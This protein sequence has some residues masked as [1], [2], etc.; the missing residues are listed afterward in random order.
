[1]DYN[2]AELL[3]I[4]DSYK[5]DTRAFLS[6]L[7]AHRKP[8]TAASLGEY[9][10]SLRDSGYAAQ[11]I[12]KRITGA[13]RT[14][15]T[16]FLQGRDS[17]DGIKAFEFEQRLKEIKK[18]H[19]NT[20]EVPEDKLLSAAEVRRITAEVKVPERVRLLIRTFSVTGLR[21]SEL[22]GI[23][24]TDVHQEAKHFSARIMGKGSKE[25]RIMIPTD[26][27]ADIRRVFAGV[28]WLFETQAH[29]QYERHYVSRAIRE[30]GRQVIGK[31]ITAHTLRHTFA[32]HLIK[33]GKTVTA[34]SR[35]LGHSTTA[36][37]QDMYVHDQLGLDDI[38]SSM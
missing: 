12:N 31:R 29:T 22:L 4:K 9:A 11:T 7:R 28:A 16:V 26:L 5:S 33:S 32:T 3:A 30:A 37:T 38:I 10:E 24:V 19:L 23:R 18:M 36:I 15:R 25:R 20:R 8:M 14:I 17:H 13:K 21:V 35:Y 27:V 34:V 1:V 2:E 6:F